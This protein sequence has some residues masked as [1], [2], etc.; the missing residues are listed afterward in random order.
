MGMAPLTGFVVLMAWNMIASGIA[1]FVR[2]CGFTSFNMM[3]MGLA[4]SF[5]SALFSGCA[6]AP[7]IFSNPDSDT[8]FILMT[9]GLVGG[10]TAF[11]VFLLP[12]FSVLIQRIFPP[13]S[14]AM[15]T[16]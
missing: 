8:A 10:I 1:I 5:V 15:G 12:S 7:W 2:R 16:A 6:T 4:A 11:R 13:E 14:R 9:L 3:L